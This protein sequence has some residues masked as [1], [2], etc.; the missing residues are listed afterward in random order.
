[1]H[2]DIQL[3]VLVAAFLKEVTYVLLFDKKFSNFVK[4]FTNSNNCFL[5]EYILKCNLIL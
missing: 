1:M 5:S 2:C 3:T 4:C